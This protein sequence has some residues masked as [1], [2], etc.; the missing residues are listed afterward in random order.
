MAGGESNLYI[1]DCTGGWLVERV[2]CISWTALVDGWCRELLVYHGLH[3]WMAGGE[4]NLYI[5][6]CTGGWLVERVTCISWT[7]LVDGWCVKSNLYIMD[8]TGGWLV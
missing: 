7:A 1:M 3:W 8:C 4:S 6:D 5:M 2:T